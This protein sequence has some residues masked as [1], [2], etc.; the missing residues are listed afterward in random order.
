MRVR[1]AIAPYL[2][3]KL[4][5]DGQGALLMAIG[6]WYSDGL[7]PQTVVARALDLWPGRTRLY[8]DGYGCTVMATTAI[9][10]EP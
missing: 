4:Y 2:S 3:G 7:A 5:S 8:I 9:D 6:Q 1:A 10:Y